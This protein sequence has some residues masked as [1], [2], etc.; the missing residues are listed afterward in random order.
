MLGGCGPV[1]PVLRAA[2]TTFAEEPA[3]QG[4]MGDRRITSGLQCARG[5]LPLVRP[6]RRRLLVQDAPELKDARER[7]GHLAAVDSG[8]PLRIVRARARCSNS[9][10]GSW[11]LR[12]VCVGPIIGR[13]T[14]DITSFGNANRLTIRT[15]GVANRIATGT[16]CRL[17]GSGTASKASKDHRK[18]VQLRSLGRATRSEDDCTTVSVPACMRAQITTL[19]FWAFVL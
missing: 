19:G 14:Q 3:R 11:A 1:R 2:R 6:V 5:W 9:H 15:Q 17:H 16:G 8:G 10:T 7:S 12:A 18:F 4:C 13:P